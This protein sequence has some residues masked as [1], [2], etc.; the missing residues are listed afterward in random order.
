MRLFI[1]ATVLTAVPALA[2]ESADTTELQDNTPQRFGYVCHAHPPGNEWDC[3]HVETGIFEEIVRLRA[4]ADC[5]RH[6]GVDCEVT[7]ERDRRRRS[8]PTH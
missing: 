5:I 8:L 2:S 1:L 3:A 6:H 7:C 4:D